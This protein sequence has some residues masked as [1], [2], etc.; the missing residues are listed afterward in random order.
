MPK[1]RIERFTVRSRNVLALSQAEAESL[2]HDSIGTEHILLGLLREEGG[3]AARVLRDV[4]VQYPGARSLV[5]DVNPLTANAKLQL[6]ANTRTLLERAV[7]EARRRGQDFIGTEHLLMAITGLP[8]CKAY[9]IL[10]R[11][12]VD[13]EGVYLRASNLVFG[14]DA[15]AFAAS[16][17]LATI[18]F[19]CLAEQEAEQLRSPSVEPEHLF[20]ALLADADSSALRLVS[21]LN[22]S[23]DRL[24]GMAQKI[25]RDLPAQ[26][27]ESSPSGPI[28][29]HDALQFTRMYPGYFPEPLL[30][31][32]VQDWWVLSDLWK[33]A[34]LDPKAVQAALDR[35]GIGITMRYP[36]HIGAAEYIQLNLNFFVPPFLRRKLMAMLRSIQRRFSGKDEW[37]K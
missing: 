4:G 29:S 11:L 17:A 33:Q 30:M 24:R 9:T 6:S 14:P 37:P 25:K 27:V 19:L 2:H 32:L 36:R 28:W 15:P 20:L 3:I 21:E 22:L 8:Q 5:K 23:L 7:D 31:V 26:Q 13:M 12:N 35:A 18:G 16:A 1:N 10:K 34:L